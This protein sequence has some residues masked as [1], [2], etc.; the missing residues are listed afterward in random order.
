MKI[1]AI[2]VFANREISIINDIIQWE[3]RHPY[4]F[5]FILSVLIVSYIIFSTPSLNIS[6]EDL[7]PVETIQFI[8]IE[9]ISAPKRIVRK[10]I[11]T[12]ATT[13]NRC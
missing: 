7:M 6:D 11:S 13:G 9:T 4:A 12:E 8:D 2:K 10:E 1:V 5:S 3:R